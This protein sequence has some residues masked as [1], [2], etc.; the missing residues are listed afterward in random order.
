MVITKKKKLMSMHPSPAKIGD[1]FQTAFLIRLGKHYRMSKWK[2]RE[3]TKIT[4]AI[5]LI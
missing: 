4:V 3:C 1:I 5:D 2:I